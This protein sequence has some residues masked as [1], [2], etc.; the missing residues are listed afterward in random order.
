[1]Q[2]RNY[3]KYTLQK[4]TPGV[5]GIVGVLVADAPNSGLLRGGQK[6]QM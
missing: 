2:R 5:V 6:C 4:T 3:R 1:M